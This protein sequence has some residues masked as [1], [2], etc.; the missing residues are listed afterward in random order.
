MR[1]YICLPAL[2]LLIV[3]ASVSSPAIASGSS[4]DIPVSAS[5]Q[6][7][8]VAKAA[9][10]TSAAVTPGPG[11]IDILKGDHGLY[12]RVPAPASNGTRLIS[13]DDYESGITF[14]NNTM[15]LPLY[16]T[17]EQ[18]GALVVTTDNLTADTNGYAGMV[19]SL[20]L[21]SGKI[22][23]A[24]DG[25]NF[26]A[27]IVISLTGLPAGATYCVAFSDNASLSEA[28]SA[29]LEIYGQTAAVASPALYVS[30]SVPAAGDMVSFV[31]ATFETDE[32]WTGR[33]G[34]KN[35]TFYS[36]AGGQLSRL[37]FTAGRSESGS[38]TYQAIFPGAGQFL[39]VDAAPRDQKETTTASSSDIVLLGGLLATL[40]IALAVMVRRVIKR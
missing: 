11:K 20:G 1:Y 19:T 35:I 6:I 24:R 4:I 25:H 13:L 31:I 40:V 26:T 14:R 3:L 15:L 32:N 22:V 38:L 17:G 37:R 30:A 18:T 33:Y 36:Y 7:S 16:S 39:I 29:D 2:C 5:F 23:A 21:A 28:I 12:I 10:N 8:G 34:D 27:S 9:D